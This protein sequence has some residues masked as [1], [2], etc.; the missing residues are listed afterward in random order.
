MEVTDICKVRFGSTEEGQL[1]QA[2]VQGRVT[3]GNSA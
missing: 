3:G 1:K 2:K